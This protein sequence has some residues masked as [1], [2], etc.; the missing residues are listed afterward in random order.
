MDSTDTILDM[1]VLNNYYK[2]ML[3]ERD[4][5]SVNHTSNHFCRKTSL[6]YCSFDHQ[7]VMPPSWSIQ[8]YYKSCWHKNLLKIHVIVI[9]T[10]LILLK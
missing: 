8:N 9:K 10:S 2:S 7:L 5:Q 4:C 1:T 3:K 6:I